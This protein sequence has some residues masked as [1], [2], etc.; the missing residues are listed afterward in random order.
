ML[1]HQI[2]VLV[3]YHCTLYKTWRMSDT[4]KAVQTSL[5]Y[6]VLIL[7]AEEHTVLGGRQ[8]ASIMFLNPTL[9]F[10]AMPRSI[11]R[12]GTRSIPGHL[13]FRS[14]VRRRSPGHMPHGLL[15]RQRS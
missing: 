4:R 15:P 6:V 2:G 7:L 11:A 8:T 13:C 10:S 5:S 3:R 12:C 9:D 14:A 1:D